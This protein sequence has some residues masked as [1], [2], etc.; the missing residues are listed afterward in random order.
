MRDVWVE[1]KSCKRKL[2]V[3]SEAVLRGVRHGLRQAAGAAPRVFEV[4]AAVRSATVM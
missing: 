4:C 1:G 3:P 2:R